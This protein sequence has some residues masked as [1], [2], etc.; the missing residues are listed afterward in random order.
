MAIIENLVTGRAKREF[1]NAIF[2]RRYGKNIMRTKP[3]VVKNPKTLKQRQHR[4]KFAL[5]IA[6]SRMVLKFSRLSFK[7]IATDIICFNAFTKEN[8][9]TAISG[10]YPTYTINYPALVVAKGTLTGAETPT[11]VAAVGKIV[12]VTWVDNSGNGDADGTDEALVLLINATK[13]VVSMNPI[14][15]T[16][17]DGSLQIIVPA[18][19]VGNQVHAYISFKA[20][21][22]NKVADSIYIS[23]VTILA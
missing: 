20:A 17:V 4:T 1:G 2:A 7:Q 12:N 22:G 9:D 11:A 23:S 14:L 3:L 21:I 13:K 16:R 8:M 19:W 5:M 6:T 15:K 18:T 10:V